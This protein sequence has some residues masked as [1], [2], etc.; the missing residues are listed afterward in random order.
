MTIV[1]PLLVSTLRAQERPDKPDFAG[2][3]VLETP[4]DAAVWEAP[5]L[6]V[7]RAGTYMVGVRT[8]KTSLSAPGAGPRSET[9]VTWDHATLVI[10]LDD[11]PKGNSGPH[12]EHDEAWTLD[13]QDRLRI[14]VADR[15][16]PAE[17]VTK[18]FVFR[19]R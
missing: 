6:S 12:T 18:E 19:R 10:R 13:P 11:W 2:H 3:W 7:V 9:L 8:G 17:P 1:V 14:A 16:T 4:V 5:G 15:E